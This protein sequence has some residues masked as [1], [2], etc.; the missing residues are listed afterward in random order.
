M[1]SSVEGQESKIAVLWHQRGIAGKMS[2]VISAIMVV[3]HLLFISGTLARLGIYIMI[4]AHAGLSLCFMLVIIFLTTP[5]RRETTRKNLPWYDVVLI[6]MSVAGAGYFFAFFDLASMHVE[7]GEPTMLETALFVLL[8]IATCEAARRLI[9]WVLPVVALFFVSHALF[10]EYFPG[11]L[12]GRSF[13]INRLTTTFYLGDSGIFG[14]PM[15]V[16]ATIVAAFIIFAEMLRQSGAADFFLKLAMSLF[17]QVRGGPAKIAVFASALFATLSGTISGNVAATGSVTIPLMKSTGYKPHFAA[18]VEAVASKGGQLTPPIMGSV[19]FIMAEMTGIGYL[20]VCIA[21]AFPALLYFTAIF[22]QVDFE[23]AKTGMKG[24]PREQIPSLKKTMMEGWHY[25]VPLIALIVMIALIKYEPQ[26]AALYSLVILGLIMVFRKE[27]RIGPARLLTACESAA[28]LICIAGIACA[29][30]GVVI[31][32]LMGTGLGVTFSAQLLYLSGGSLV[33]LLGLTALACYIMG[34][35]MSSI[36]IYIILAILVAPALVEMGVPLEAAHLF[37]IYW[38]NVAFITPP[39]CIAAYVAASIAKASP[40]RTGWQAVRLGIVT[41]IVPFIFVYDPALI[42]IGE[43]ARIVLAVITSIGG[44]I[45]LAAG[46]EGYVFKPANW[47]ERAV[48][49]AGGLLLVFPGW[50]TDL[51]GIGIVSPVALRQVMAVRAT[52][53]AQAAGSKTATTSD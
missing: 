41:F 5:A 30:A 47:I 28:K 12:S 19:A 11:I 33:V 34:M 51:I 4:T 46:L 49:L 52:R 10:T 9:G 23:A 6:L 26:M 7:L 15:I 25:I 36:A 35:G 29:L 27:A 14:I 17:G 20:A 24:V 13:S 3:Y 18:A 22:F 38:G 37:V 16:A 42:M 39:V 1:I 50:T 53:Q 8:L 43:P 48:L 44:V 32:S 31:G 40:M 45:M 21:A 2:L